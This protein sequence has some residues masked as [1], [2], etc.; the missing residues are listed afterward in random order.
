MPQ[1]INLAK[2]VLKRTPRSLE[3][4]RGIELNLQEHL[5]CPYRPLATVAINDL[6]DLVD[7]AKGVVDAWHASDADT[8]TS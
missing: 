6:M 7:M 2:E 3:V 4:L 1:A 5:G 8:A